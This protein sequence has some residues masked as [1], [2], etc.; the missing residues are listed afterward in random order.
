MPLNLHPWVYIG[1]MISTSYGFPDLSHEDCIFSMTQRNFQLALSWDFRNHSIVPTH[2]TVW[3]TVMSKK[4]DMKIVENCVNITRPFCNLTDLWDGISETFYKLKITGNTPGNVSFVI[5]KLIPNTNHCVSVY[6]ES[7]SLSNIIR[8]PLKC[9]FLPEQLIVPKP[10]PVEAVDKV[11]VIVVKRKK[12][13]WNYSYGA[14]SDSEEESTPRTCAGGYTTRGMMAKPLIQACTP[15]SSPEESPD[16]DT[17]VDDPDLPEPEAEP[18]LESRCSLEQSEY[19][20]GA[21]KRGESA[22]Q[23]LFSEEDSISEGSGDGVVF[24]VD[25]NSVFVRALA[26]DDDTDSQEEMGGLDGTS[27]VDLGCTIPMELEIQPPDASPSAECWLS[28]DTASEKS[29]ASE[30]DVDVGDGYIMR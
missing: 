13:V 7:Q 26:D 2:Y 23:D 5:E 24:N 28:E 14:D 18:L 3:H 8:S 22:S 20:S 27:E 16:I 6:F 15:Q 12:K 10:P 9:V 21:Y 30:S 17:E 1:L 25:L 11:E 4:E 19:V 29:N